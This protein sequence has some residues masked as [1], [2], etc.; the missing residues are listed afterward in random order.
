MRRTP[1]VIDRN[2]S[3]ERARQRERWTETEDSKRQA[4]T[5]TQRQTAGQRQIIFNYDYEI[6][7]S[8]SKTVSDAWTFTH[9]L[10]IS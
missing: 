10:W 5:H 2:R 9:R 1:R 8:W 3:T 6:E 7:V 4:D